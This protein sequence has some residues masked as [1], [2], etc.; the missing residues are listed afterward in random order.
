[1]THTT[2]V[3]PSSIFQFSPQ[4]PFIHILASPANSFDSSHEKLL[5]RPIILKSQSFNISARMRILNLRSYLKC[6]IVN[7]NKSRG[8]FA[9]LVYRIEDTYLKLHKA[10][11]HF[12]FWPRLKHLVMIPAYFRRRYWMAGDSTLCLELISLNNSEESDFMFKLSLG[13]TPGY[14]NALLV[15]FL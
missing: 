2:P 8:C 3:H 5:L 14:H 6:L 1:M 10:P 7:K 15:Y 9:C 13:N 11:W 12:P 4:T